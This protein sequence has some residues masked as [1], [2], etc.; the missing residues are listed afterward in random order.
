MRRRY[1]LRS[2][3]LYNTYGSISY[4]FIKTSPLEDDF[5]RNEIGYSLLVDSYWLL[6]N[7]NDKRFLNPK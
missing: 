1:R 5:I 2:I 6:E 3:E 4:F 7:A